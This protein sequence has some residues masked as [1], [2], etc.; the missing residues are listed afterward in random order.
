MDEHAS[1]NIVKAKEALRLSTANGIVTTDQKVRIYIRELD[2]WLLAWVLEETPLVIS[3]DDLVKNHNY[4]FKMKKLQGKSVAWLTK[5][6]KKIR[7]PIV[8]G[9]PVLQ[10]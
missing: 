5:G 7:L 10:V 4:E 1:K 3:V 6:S 9:V 2:T 8:Q